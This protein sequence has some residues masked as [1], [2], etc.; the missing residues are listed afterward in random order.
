M[1]HAVKYLLEFGRFRID[2][3]QRLLL[4][5]QE[6]IPLSPKAFELLL[7]LAQRNGQVVLKEELMNLL[8]PDTFVE[9]SNLGQ[10]IFQ[11][12][13]ALGESAQSPAYIVTVPGRGYRFA[14]KVRTASAED[15]EEIVLESHSQSRVV[16][17]EET[18]AA[19]PPGVATKFR[20][21][22]AASA[23]LVLLVAAAFWIVP[24][25]PPPKVLRV[26]QITHSGRVEPYGRVLTDG[27][28]IY[29]TERMGG[30][31]A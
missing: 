2:P 21:G 13:K 19:P 16:I 23:S 12:R 18:R 5:D 7:V 4:R 10:H 1:A 20:I 27:S 24:V 14:Q 6:P 9:E 29:F 8:W 17:E 11:L 3:E 31:A 25:Q 26:R 15:D 28:R 22:L 30:T